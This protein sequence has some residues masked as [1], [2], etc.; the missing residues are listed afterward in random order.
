MVDPLR[1][2]QLI[3]QAYRE[4]L[5]FC[6]HF[7][8]NDDLVKLRKAFEL[9]L[10]HHRQAESKAAEDDIFHS[11][12]VA[13]IVSEE[14]NLGTTSVICAL[15]HDV[16]GD[17]PSI[18]AQISN[19][20]GSDVSVILE[21]FT[22]LS[23]IK[24]EKVSLHSD[25]YRQLFLSLIKDI[26]V[27][28][29]KLAHRLYDMRNFRLL[30]EEKRV[31]FLREVQFIYIPIAHRLGLYAIKTELEDL[32]M[33]H[34]HAAIYRSIERQ[35]KESRVKQNA[36]ITDFIRPIERELMKQ[37][38]DFE[39]KGRPKSIHSVWQKMKKQN[40][41]FDE[42]YDLFAVRIILNVTGKN[43]KSECWKVYS[44]VTDIYQPNTKRL[45]DWISTPKPSGYESLH[46][47]VE[48]LNK[49]WV[50]IQIRTVRMDEMAEKGLV[51]HW[52]YKEGATGK[53]H[54]EWM[55]KI[56]DFIANM[57]MEM[58]EGNDLSRIDLYAHQTFVF[59]PEGDL[60]KLPQGATVLDFAYDIHSS[61]G[62]LC[63][64]AR[65]NG[66]Q[67]P[68]RHVLQSGD[69]VEI[70]T[71]KNQR[72]KL[73]WLGFVITNKA[74]NKIKRAL[75]EQRFQEAEMGKDILRR[76]LRN[77]KIQF[78]DAIIDKLIKQFK[79][80]SSVDLY[81]LIA[82]EK[83]DVNEIKKSIEDIHGAGLKPLASASVKEPEKED[84][85]TES[86]TK[87]FMVIDDGIDNLGY[88]L[89]KCCH[90]VSGD[91]VFGFVTIGKGIT[92]HRLNC[93]NARQLL[94]KYNYRVISVKWRKTDEN[95]TYLSTIHVT[96]D[97]KVGVLNNITSVI[98]NDLK[99]NMVSLNVDTSKEG[100]FD[101]KI[102]VSVRDTRHI[103]SLIYQV[104]KVKG[105][106]KATRSLT[107]ES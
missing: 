28:L 60:K 15:L 93:P 11:V 106:R 66:K 4:L 13:R 96:G 84:R 45:R 33:K 26:R 73:D 50:E 48:A 71:S 98:S 62:D 42:V 99:V 21:G 38:F 1:E 92:I 44:I 46:A 80:K 94:S 87:D 16:R 41:G 30:P 31:R 57:D 10:E 8:K 17:D 68:I 5:S 24:T 37:G 100:K 85:Q 101:A 29:I 32:W 54:E 72:P 40:V 49:K 82:V 107:E 65:V 51:S 90:P 78:S 20:F 23:K 25:K 27:I 39:I 83:I 19:D 18:A 69:K 79:L 102:K 63:S 56:R 3:K 12:K 81:Y 77:R 95:R 35:M 70:L 75:K 76:K 47:T 103:E 36:F 61:L 55:T 86:D 64:G 74:K 91:A 6:K 2:K 89:A 22:R 53:E 34:S 9:L 14:L 105:V 88:E 97:D 67:V 59:T 58:L 104:L 52:R 7:A 43:E